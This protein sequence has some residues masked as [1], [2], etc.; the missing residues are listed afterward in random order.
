M[1]SSPTINSGSA[2]FHS[3]ISL[4]CRS[5]NGHLLSAEGR[6]AKV[7][8]TNWS[9]IFKQLQTSEP[10]LT[11]LPSGLVVETRSFSIVPDATLETFFRQNAALRAREVYRDADRYYVG[12]LSY[13]PQVDENTPFRD[14]VE[15]FFLLRTTLRPQPYQEWKFSTGPNCDSRSAW[16]TF[17]SWVMA[18]KTTL[19]KKRKG[20]VQRKYEATAESITVLF[21]RMLRNTADEDRW[22]YGGRTFFLRRVIEFVHRN[23]ACQM[24]LPA[25]PCKSPNGTKAGGSKPDMAERIALESLRDFAMSVKRIYSPGATIHVVHDGHLLSSCIGVDDAAISEYE[26]NLQELYRSHFDSLEDQN[27]IKFISLND[28]FFTKTNRDMDQSLDKAWLYDAEVL[29][30]PLQTR[31]SEPIELVRKLVMASCGVDRA[32]LRKLIRTQD[33][34]TI[35]TYRGLSRFMLQDLATTGSSE[36]RSMSQRKKIASAVAAEMMARNQAYTNLLELL[37]PDFVRLSI[38]AHS[39]QGPKFSVR[40]FP[41]GRVRAVDDIDGRHKPAPLHDFQIPTPWHSCIVKVRDDNIVYLTKA[42]VARQALANGRYT[43]RWVDDNEVGEEGQGHFSLCE[44]V[45]SSKDLAYVEAGGDYE[46]DGRQIK[47]VEEFEAQ[48]QVVR[49]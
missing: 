35:S 48:K 42:S 12:L 19:N 7:L 8:A 20:S 32:H 9:V 27:A 11:S 21:E 49:Q 36:Q 29:C 33:A 40:L 23:E 14:W 3:I 1:K 26:S 34:A 44:V 2:P 39:N 22:D 46:S 25:F 16:K 13:Q 30:H 47:A 38:H 43:G 4:Y 37:F 6:E 41:R 45:A 31:L 18:P 24:V 10:D 15:T 28:L 5:C 17:C